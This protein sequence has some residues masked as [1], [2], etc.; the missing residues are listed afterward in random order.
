MTIQEFYKT[1]YDNRWESTTYSQEKNARSW[2][3]FWSLVICSGFEFNK[4]ALTDLVTWAEESYY[5]TFHRPDEGHYCDAVCDSNIQFCC[6]Y[7]SLVRR[8]PFIAKHCDYRS[9]AGYTCHSY[10]KSQGRL[11]IGTRFAWKEHTVE[12]TSFKDTLHS[13]IACAYK[14]K[15]RD[16][17]YE[18]AKIAKR[19]TLP[20]KD[21]LASRP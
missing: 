1:F 2:G 20:H 7:E 8:K 11:V 13:L 10:E 4:D 15:S 6:A 21:W 12:V 19:F 17:E 14:P 3:A 18:P 5:R 9:R 16:V